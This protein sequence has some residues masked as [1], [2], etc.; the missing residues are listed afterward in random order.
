MHGDKTEKEASTPN[1]RKNT[2]DARKLSECMETSRSFVHV[3]CSV[4][5]VSA[6]KFNNIS[7]SEKLGMTA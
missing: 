4:F 1:K 7:L 2:N 3:A 6:Q 5:R